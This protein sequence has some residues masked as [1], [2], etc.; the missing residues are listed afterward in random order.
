MIGVADNQSS[1]YKEIVD[2]LKEMCNN[3][4]ITKRSLLVSTKNILIKDANDPAEE[5]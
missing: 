1:K 2:S 3:G 4:E 5:V